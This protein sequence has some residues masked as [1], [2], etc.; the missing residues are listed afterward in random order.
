MAQLQR[1]ARSQQRRAVLLPLTS[2]PPCSSPL[3]AGSAA[4]RCTTAYCA[5]QRSAF[6]S[7]RRGGRCDETRP[8]GRRRRSRVVLA[9]APQLS[10]TLNVHAPRGP[11]RARLAPAR[12][13]PTTR[14]FFFP[15]LPGKR[16]ARD[17]VGRLKDKKPGGRGGQSCCTA[18]R[19][20]CGAW[21]PQAPATATAVARRRARTACRVRRSPATPDRP[22]AIHKHPHPCP[23]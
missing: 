1:V 22:A 5:P 18:A 3:H 4:T 16:K 10:N 12:P 13:L 7:S 23:S 15:A 17:G 6:T 14:P 19:A 11:H 21:Q 8:R 2:G 20:R 9:V